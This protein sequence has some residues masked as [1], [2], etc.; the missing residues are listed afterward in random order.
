MTATL[1]PIEGPT[2]TTGQRV[3]YRGMFGETDGPLGRVSRVCKGYIKVRQDDG[4][5]VDYH[6]EDLAPI[7]AKGAR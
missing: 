5:T 4:Q 1:R 6:P 2:F 7:T 3:Q